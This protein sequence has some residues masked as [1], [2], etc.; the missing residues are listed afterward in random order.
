MSAAA[1]AR[2]AGVPKATVSSWLAGCHPR[3]IEPVKAIAKVLGCTPG[4]LLAG[5]SGNENET[6]SGVFIDKIEAGPDGWVTV[7]L[8]FKKL[9]EME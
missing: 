6:P 4:E 9:G 5:E 7:K 3:K 1:L 2:S 8:R